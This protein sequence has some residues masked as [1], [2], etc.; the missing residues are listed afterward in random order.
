MQ[1]VSLPRRDRKKPSKADLKILS[2]SNVQKITNFLDESN[3]FYI[4]FH[5]GFN[6]AMRVSEICGM[7]WEMIDLDE[8]TMEVDKA[9]VNKDGKWVLGQPK[10]ASS[11]R[12]FRIG[13]NFIAILRKHKLQQKKNKLKYGVHYHDSDFVCNKENGQFVTPGS[14]KWN[15]RNIREKLDID[16]NFHSLRHTHATLLLERSA[17]IKDI[18][19][20]LGNARASP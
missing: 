15:G 2:L 6:T 16:F 9:M 10:N 11:Y 3:T 13:D 19:A 12:K 4:P 20:K 7:M 17:P 14:C 8:G 1:Y 5:M 18:Q